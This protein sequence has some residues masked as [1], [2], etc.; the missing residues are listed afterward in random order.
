MNQEP[1]QCPLPHCS[2]QLQQI[3]QRTEVI[4]KILFGRAEENRP[5]LIERHNANERVVS[6]IQR[7]L[8][9]V[10]TAVIGVLVSGVAGLFVINRSALKIERAVEAQPPAIM[11]PAKPPQ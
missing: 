1:D 8:D 4:E 6:G 10:L 7:R 3:M 2:H 11:Q 5:G 9:Q